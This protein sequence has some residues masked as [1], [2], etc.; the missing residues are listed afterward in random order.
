MVGGRDYSGGLLQRALGRRAPAHARLNLAAWQVRE[1]LTC[2][3]QWWADI[4]HRHE[5]RLCR[6]RV[7]A[8][9]RGGEDGIRRATVLCGQIHIIACGAVGGDGDVGA[10]QRATRHF[11][12]LRCDFGSEYATQGRG[13]DYVV[14][15]LKAFIAA[16]PYFRVIP[17]PPHAHAFNKAENT[18]HQITGHAFANACRARLGPAAWSILDEGSCF[19]HNCR[20]VWR[21]EGVPAETGP[22]VSRMEALTGR[23][24]DVSA[25]VGFVGQGGWVRKWDVKA[26]AQRDKATPV[27][28]MHPSSCGVGHVVYNLETC[29]K[30]LAYSLSVTTDPQAISLMLAQS[31]M[32]RPRGAYGTPDEVEYQLCLRAMLVPRSVDAHTPWCSMIP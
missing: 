24:P 2:G 6:A 22:L 14:A 13:D 27:I 17:C 26:N 5:P 8:P 23:R 1:R 30:Q 31:A 29:T 4:G 15:G 28:Y 12:F 9:I 3:E 10:P 32:T 19:Q 7:H 20:P 21:P 18:I 11:R 16:R 25:M